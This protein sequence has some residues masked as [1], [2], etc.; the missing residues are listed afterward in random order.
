MT[1][2]TLFLGNT[3][4]SPCDGMTSGIR[5]KIHATQL[6]RF[7]QQL[8]KPKHPNDFLALECPQFVIPLIRSVILIVAKL[9]KVS[10]MA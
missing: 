9:E 6:H 10:D 2:A 3:H 1:V 8:L 4:H 5:T 7:R